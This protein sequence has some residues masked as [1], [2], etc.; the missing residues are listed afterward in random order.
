M[1]PEKEELPSQKNI[2]NKYMDVDLDRALDLSGAGRYQV[3][4]C[5][6]MLAVISTVIVEMI[7]N[8]FI[9]PAAVCDLGLSNSLRGLLTSVPNIGVILTA[10]VWGR[11]AD[12]LGR[13]PVLLFS[14]AVSGIFALVAAFMPNLISFALFKFASSLFLSCPSSLGFAYAGELMPRQKRDLAV[15]ICNALSMLTS[16]FCPLLA[17]GILSYN[18]DSSPIPLRPWR[19]LTVVYAAP[20]ICAAIWVTQAKESPKFLMAKGRHE[21]AL[22]VLK[23][24]YA[25][26]TGLDKE[27]Y[28]VKSLKICSDHTIEYNR[29]SPSSEEDSLSL[30][31]PP[32]LKWLVLIG[33]LMFGLFS[34][35]NGLFLFVPFTLNKAVLSDKPRTVCEL[36]NQP[37]NQTSAVCSDTISYGTFQVTVICSLVYGTLVMLVSLSSVSKRTQLIIM[38]SLVGVTCIISAL[39]TNKLLAGISMSALQI[40]ALGIG[41]LTAYAV[42]MF[43]T[44][45]RGTAVGAVLMFGRVG[46]V[47]G[48][49]LA[50][51]FLAGSC[52]ATFYG[53]SGLL[54]LCAFLSA[55]LQREQTTNQVT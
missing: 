1:K 45:L 43:P 27:N 31:K 5:A 46:S 11:A 55:F 28:C 48:A 49:N 4:H 14:T 42:E 21:E 50:G 32:H 54:F 33:F 39:T 26:N 13:K 52:T 16:T 37:Q 29:D 36:I 24:I 18:W 47:V 30:L 17:W 41:P 3:F 10:P 15:M 44:T 51:V 2:Q 12:A 22:D 20:V 9:L 8:A 34:L 23:H 53:F 38:Y 19:V 7:G 35:L 25:F 6:M 40:T